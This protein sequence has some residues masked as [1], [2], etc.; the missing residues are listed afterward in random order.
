VF[1]W[2]LII[3]ISEKPVTTAS[4]DKEPVQVLAL[5]VLFIGGRLTTLS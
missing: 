5:F 1:P 4:K 2:Q 3:S